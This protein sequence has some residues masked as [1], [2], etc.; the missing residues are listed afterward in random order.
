MNKYEVK[1][2]LD[3][4]IFAA[5][6]APGAPT[7]IGE[8]KLLVCYLLYSVNKDISFSR[9]HRILTDRDLVNYFQLVEVLEQMTASKH[10]AVKQTE[11]GDEYCLTELGVRT[12]EELG[13]TLPR[14]TREKV[15]EEAE[16]LYRQDQRLLE[17][18]VEV[19][20][21]EGGYR[22]NMALPDEQRD[23]ISFSVFAPNRRECE[24]I[25]RCFLNDPLFIYKGVM[26]LLTGN[27]E[28]VGKIIPSEETLF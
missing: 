21:V 1:L 25:R 16:L 17:V 15:V 8:I 22:L 9:L 7:T 12:A 11:Q 23:L 3:R 2:R 14:S 4:E 26:A 28:V 10:I 13:E 20:D 24:R 18:S 5:G 27:R 6:L 19:V